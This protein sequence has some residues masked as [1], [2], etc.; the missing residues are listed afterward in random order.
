MGGG[1]L[2]KG[3]RRSSSGGSHGGASAVAP[4]FWL[5]GGKERAVWLPCEVEWVVVKPLRGWQGWRPSGGGSTVSWGARRQWRRRVLLGAGESS[6]LVSLG[7][8]VER[9][10]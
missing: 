7:S 6:A 2:E 10:G 4:A 1:G 3:A 5:G 9:R 8:R